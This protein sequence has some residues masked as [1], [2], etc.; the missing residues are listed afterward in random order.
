[1]SDPAAISAQLVNIRNIATHK[2][3]A[4]TLHCP[5]EHAQ[6][7]I[8]AFG[9]PT[10]SAPVP[11]AIARLDVNGGCQEPARA[12]VER[13]DLTGVPPGPHRNGRHWSDLTPAQQTGVIRNEPAFWQF[14]DTAGAES[15]AEFIRSYCSVKSCA[16]IAPGTESAFRWAQL[17]VRYGAFL[18]Q[19]RNVA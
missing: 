17:Q 1:M 3:I 11:V 14:S 5:E 18:R 9:W 19:K 6:A 16:D 7:V 12:E 13:P 2:S 10:M 15:A 8:T 4:L